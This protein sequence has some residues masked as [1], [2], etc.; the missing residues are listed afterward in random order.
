MRAMPDRTAPRTS[1]TIPKMTRT[2]A[3]IHRIVAT[4]PP[5]MACSDDEVHR[6][7]P[8]VADGQGL[9]HADDRNRWTLTGASSEARGGA[10]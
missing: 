7:L 3:M 9:P 10:R 4:P 2:T 5:Q 6:V 1:V 8:S